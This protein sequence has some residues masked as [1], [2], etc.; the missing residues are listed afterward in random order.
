MTNWIET[1]ERLDQQLL[2]VINGW[3]GNQVLDSTMIFFSAKWVWI[4][5]YA[6]LLYLIWRHIGTTYLLYIAVGVFGLTVITD[7][8]SVSFFKDV[9]QRYRP[10]HNEL[11]VPDLVLPTGRCGGQF[12]F[13]SSHASNVFGLS[14]F[15]FIL[16]K[17]QSKLWLLM[18]PWAAFVALSRV[19][20]GVHYPSDIVAGSLYGTVCGVSMGFLT[21][22]VISEV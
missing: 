11:L 7:Q 16:M 17:G 6:L 14:A 3:A 4:P 19:Y 9:F 13:I 5:L 22:H 21:R 1:L 12:S 18:F 2:L 8:G 10:C 15:L 20:L